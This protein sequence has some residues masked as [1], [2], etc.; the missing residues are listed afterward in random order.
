MINI[1]KSSLFESIYRPQGFQWI[2][3]AIGLA[4]VASLIIKYQLDAAA[5]KKEY[6]SDLQREN[7]L[8]EEKISKRLHTIHQGLHTLA[9][10][11]GIA[12]AIKNNGAF[13]PLSQR[14]VQELYNFLHSSIQ[15]TELYIVP[16]DFE[17]TKIEQNSGKFHKTI[18]KLEK[19][20]SVTHHD[21]LLHQ[22]KNTKNVQFLMINKD[23]VALEPQKYSEILKQLNY[24]N[25]HYPNNERI[26]H[27]NYPALLSKEVEITD[28]E[29]GLIYSLPIYDETGNLAGMVS[30]IVETKMIQQFLTKGRYVLHSPEYQLN[31]VSPK[32][33]AWETSQS[34]YTRNQPDPGLLYSNTTR[35]DIPDVR[36]NWY[37]WNGVSER[38]FDNSDR[39]LMSMFYTT[40]ALLVVTLTILGISFYARILA[41]KQQQ[42][43]NQNLLLEKTVQK[44]T[45]ELKKSEAMAKAIL[46]N[47]ADGIVITDRNGI[48]VKANRAAQTAF[49]YQSDGITG[50][51]I[52]QLIPD[53]NIDKLQLHN[54]DI[55]LSM[56]SNLLTEYQG[57]RE[58]G[59]EFT[60]EL[61]LS[62][63][64]VN[65]EQ[66]YTSVFRD[67][68]E[69]KK[70][71]LD[72]Q[73]AKDQAEQAT[74][75]KSEFLA[76]MSHELRTPLNAIIGY[77]ELLQDDFISN[78]HGHYNEDINKILSAGQQLLYLVN[79]IL[80][81]SKIESGKMELYLER[82]QILEL[83]QLAVDAVN[84]SMLK[85]NNKILVRVAS[86]LE[87]EADRTKLYQVILNLLNNANKFTKDGKISI[88]VGKTDKYGIDWLELTVQDT[89]IGMNREQLNN[90]FKSF[91]QADSS[92]TRRYGGTGLGL[93]ISRH[94][95]EMMGGSIMVHSEPE[96][97]T[98]FTV[99]L[100][101]EVIGPKADPLKIRF[102]NSKCSSRRLKISRVLIVGDNTQSIDLIERFLTREGFFADGAIS[103][104]QALNLARENRPDVIVIDENSLTFD[105]WNNLVELK[106][107]HFLNNIPIIMLTKSDSKQLALAIGATD[108]ISKP[109]QRSRLVD[110][111]TKYTRDKSYNSESNNYLLVID[112]DESNRLMM[113]RMLETEGFNVKVADNG[114]S[115]IKCVAEK[116][117]ALI[118]LDIMMPVMNGFE[119]VD[120]LRE[121]PDWNNVP[122]ITVT[123]HELSEEQRN[124][125]HGQV[126]AIISKDNLQPAGLL[127]KMREV[128]VNILRQEQQ[129]YGSKR[130]A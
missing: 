19:A 94:F 55:A 70:Y 54:N 75:A 48:I 41:K 35:L 34:W 111:V 59:S 83:I 123:G 89:G 21:A 117:P 31:I 32:S 72:I 10:L 36:K 64:S 14:V 113:Q 47:A 13:E 77:S 101:M 105:G 58:D 93:S 63:F 124:R 1:E 27:H 9:H 87:V 74:R 30:S 130:S 5:L 76:T 17:S 91:T 61:N 4:L 66:L 102:D 120:A 3:Y 33:G 71:E 116:K 104:I 49:Y 68:T 23:E 126:E 82:F 122:V 53:F 85:N 46:D 60:L 92:T 52:S 37:L 44:R 40:I 28:H 110:I 73:I 121:N 11:P 119:F 109:I 97:G 106:K 24:F 51:P 79:S 78:Q 8:V 62:E 88:A 99:D 114:E 81:L 84:P 18:V 103:V 42:V 7:A 6:I 57:I 95:C 16:S 108:Y 56:Q 118:F 98:S 38:E 96:K 100:P 90:I 112:D 128:V 86:D 2:I 45:S 26:Q 65:D 125:L 80:D 43:E 127:Q 50:T 15:L 20:Y 39:V 115:G 29:K 25:S 107:N 67:I 69:R 22:H 12:I 129:N